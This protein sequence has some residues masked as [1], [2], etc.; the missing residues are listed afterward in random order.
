MPLNLF[1]PFGFTKKLTDEQKAR[2]LNIEVNNGRLAST[3]RPRFRHLPPPAPPATRQP[4]VTRLIDK[5]RRPITRSTHTPLPPPPPTPAPPCVRA[6]LGLM[7][8]VAEARVPGAVP[9]LVGK[10]KP[11]AGE[12]MAPF[13]AADGN[14]PLVNGM[15]DSA[16]S[17]FN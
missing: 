3:P 16:S 5:K 14:L 11:Y 9:A 7:G 1:D 17:W 12:V 6:V 15:L 2:K 13:S 10:I 8:F 4:T